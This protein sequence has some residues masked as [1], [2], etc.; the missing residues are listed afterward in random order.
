VDDLSSQA[1]VVDYD[2]MPGPDKLR[3]A[4]R[5]L[6]EGYKVADAAK[7]IGTDSRHLRQTISRIVQKMEPDEAKALEDWIYHRKFYSAPYMRDLESTLAKLSSRKITKL[8]LAQTQRPDPT[9]ASTT[10]RIGNYRQVWMK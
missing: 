3:T 7:A 8:P 6:H 10:G 1:K 5:M 4:L 2:A 9:R